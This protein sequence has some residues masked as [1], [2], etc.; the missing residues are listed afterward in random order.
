MLPRLKH[1]IADTEWVIFQTLRYGERTNEQRTVLD[2]LAVNVAE[3]FPED[4]KN[5]LDWKLLRSQL[6][7][8]NVKHG[9]KVFVETLRTSPLPGTVRH[10][11]VLLAIDQFEE[12]LA[13]SAGPVAAQFLR[14][15]RELLHCRNG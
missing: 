9:V 11:T 10:A 13:P 15:L 3:L 8:D 6:I 4:A 5:T 14:F 2:Q 1:R 12:L 7:S